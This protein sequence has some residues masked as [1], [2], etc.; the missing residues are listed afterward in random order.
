MPRHLILIIAAAVAL[1]GAPSA[2]G[3]TIVVGR[4]DDPAGPCLPASGTCTLRQA[5]TAAAAGDTISLPPGS[6]HYLVTLGRIPIGKNLTI[7]GGGARATVIDGGG[8]SPLFQAT[9][10]A[11]VAF[12]GVTLTGGNHDVT[13]PGTPAG[14]GALSMTGTPH[15]TFSDAA[16]TANRAK[17]TTGNT[18]GGAIA[19]SGGSLTLTRTLVSGGTAQSTG[20]GA[21]GGAIAGTGTITLTDSTISGNS[22]SSPAGGYGGALTASAGTVLLVT[23]STIAG[24]A[25]TSFGGNMY[26]NVSGGGSAT[27]RNTIV[28]NG[29][30]TA[31]ANCALS[32]GQTTSQ[33]HN[34]DTKNECGFTGAG[35]LHDT[36]S[37]LDPL[38][39]HGGPTDTLRIPPASPAYHGG[40]AC[41]ATDQR[42]L[43]RSA[44][45]SI[46]AYEPAA[47]VIT[48]T[49][50]PDH[51]LLASPFAFQ[52]AAPP[53]VVNEPLTVSWLADDGAAGGPA[54]DLAFS[55][56][57]ATA[58]AHS[59]T[60]TATDVYG[61]TATATA[62][63]TVDAPVVPPVPPVPP[64]LTLT[65]TSLAPAIFRAATKGLPV[66]RAAAAKKKAGRTPV[67]SKAG[68]TL[69]HAARTTFALERAATGRIAGKACVK[70]TSKNRRAR[71]CT[72]YTTTAGTTARDDAGG[73]RTA[74]ISGRWKGR[75][76]QPGRYRLVVS[77]RDDAGRTAG[78]ARLRFTIVR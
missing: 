70:A 24:N 41:S 3:A 60:A 67:G 65:K 26:L 62:A 68:Y 7:T 63:V 30:S 31:G 56:A 28:A 40:L 14:G 66:A 23:G 71:A 15:V 11:T 27:F 52:A 57:F 17:T 54:A 78:P 76:L 21:Q 16:L 13:A 19:M 33:G 59:A 73:A 8:A 43:A 55:H 18:A 39:D 77:A 10:T 48:A 58:G 45:C 64:A 72:R 20:G 5:I 51:G 22:A 46:G 4:T 53:G 49:A 36:I 38:G 1:T 42:G 37:Q 6:A 47:P 74:R 25:S 69:S 35:D 29:T 44:G 75:A 32:A 50:A 12:N 9:G 34:L 2:M 61:H